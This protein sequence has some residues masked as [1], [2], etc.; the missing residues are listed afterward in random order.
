MNA[1]CHGYDISHARRS[2]IDHPDTII[3]TTPA[4]REEGKEGG[5]GGR[6]RREGKEGGEMIMQ[7]GGD[8]GSLSQ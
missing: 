6:G 2:T 5:E 7:G 8:E 1:S 4:E 3:C